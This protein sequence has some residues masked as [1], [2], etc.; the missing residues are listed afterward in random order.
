MASGTNWVYESLYP[1][2]RGR[3]PSQLPEEPVALWWTPSTLLQMV[4]SHSMQ[5]RSRG[6]NTSLS[7]WILLAWKCPGSI[8]ELHISC[9]RQCWDRCSK[10]PRGGQSG[11][12]M[13]PS[14]L[15]L[16]NAKRCGWWAEIPKQTQERA[17]GW[18]WWMGRGGPACTFIYIAWSIQT[19]RKFSVLI[20][21]SG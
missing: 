12:Q 18:D 8:P 9:K 2:A 7:K 6:Q 5:M 1:Q 20:W 15:Y 16:R 3:H 17:F 11:W 19:P 21:A 14:L 4:G 10:K 13:E